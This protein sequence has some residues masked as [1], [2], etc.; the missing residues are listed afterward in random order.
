[1]IMDDCWPPLFE[2]AA[3]FSVLCTTPI[4]E[5]LATFGGH[6]TIVDI[7]GIILIQVMASHGAALCEQEWCVLPVASLS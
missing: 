3:L 6:A 1:M 7:Y 5:W 2:Q 4:K